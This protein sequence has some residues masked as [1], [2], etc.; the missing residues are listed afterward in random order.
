MSID[1]K[2][3]QNAVKEIVAAIGEDTRKEMSKTPERVADM[4]TEIFAGLHTDPKDALSVIH[5]EHGDQMIVVRDIQFYSICEHHLTP[6]FGKAH[7]AYIPKDNRITGFSKLCELVETVAKRPQ[8]QERMGTQI[9]DAMM[10]VL[11]PFGAMVV[12]EA[13]HLCM[14]MR[15]VKKPGTTTITSAIRGVFYDD[16]SARAEALNLIHTK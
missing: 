16:S 7:I 6:F 5:E 11:T 9:V 14:S 12:I 1:K 15:G 4:Y 10:E 8:L 13:E 3:I 2:R